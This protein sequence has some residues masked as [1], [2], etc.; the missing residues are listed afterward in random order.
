MQTKHKRIQTKIHKK[1]KYTPKIHT[2]NTQKN[3]QK[4]YKNIHKKNRHKEIHKTN[5]TQKKYTKQI[6]KKDINKYT[7]TKKNKYTK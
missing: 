7:K 3:T 6:H 2:T 5:N 4:K 1:K